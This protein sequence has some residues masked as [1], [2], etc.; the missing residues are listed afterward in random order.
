MKLLS[1]GRKVVTTW[2][3]ILQLGDHTVNRDVK[4]LSRRT[5]AVATAIS[6]TDI[7][8]QLPSSIRRMHEPDAVTTD[9]SELSYVE[10]SGRCQRYAIFLS[11][12]FRACHSN[13]MRSVKERLR[14]EHANLLQNIVDECLQLKASNH[15]TVARSSRGARSDTVEGRCPLLLN[16]SNMQSI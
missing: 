2:S 9:G 4:H 6:K 3:T 8:S 14:S 10:N 5:S 12:P 15:A 13:L 7:A 1:L 11:V 16:N